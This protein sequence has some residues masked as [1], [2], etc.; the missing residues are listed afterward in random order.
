MT[1]AS[2]MNEDTPQTVWEEQE[3]LGGRLLLTIPF[4]VSVEE[5]QGFISVIGKNDYDVAPF[6]VL[7]LCVGKPVGGAIVSTVVFPSA[8]LYIDF[9]DSLH[10]DTYSFFE[11]SVA[12]IEN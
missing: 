1:F 8:D 12:L 7:T 4:G 10:C 6:P 3:A 2:K 11:R 5:M 9:V